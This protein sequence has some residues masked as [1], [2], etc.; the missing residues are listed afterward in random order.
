TP[1]REARPR[2]FR[3]LGLVPRSPDVHRKTAPPAAPKIAVWKPEPVAAPAPKAPK[4]RA[5]SGRHTNFLGLPDGS[6]WLTGSVALL[7]LLAIGCT[8][9][10]LGLGGALRRRLSDRP[11]TYFR[12]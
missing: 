1:A 6:Y 11:R 7:A 10:A 12:Y 9:A 4:A 2:G 8:V 5:T 3:V